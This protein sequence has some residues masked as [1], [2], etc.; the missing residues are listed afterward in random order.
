MAKLKRALKAIQEKKKQDVIRVKKIIQKNI[1]ANRG[2]NSGIVKVQNSKEVDGVGIEKKNVGVGR[3]Q[4]EFL[5]FDEGLTLLVGEGNFSFAKALAMK[6]QTGENIIATCLDNE[7]EVLLK[8]PDASE[9]IQEFQ[10]MGGTVFYSVDATKLHNNRKLKSKKFSRI[11]FNFPHVGMKDM[12]RNILLNKSLI[13]QFFQSTLH[14]PS[15]PK[16]FITLK[17]GSP[18]DQWD[19]KKIAKEYGYVCETSV[20]FDPVEMGVEGYTHRRTV[21]FEEGLSKSGNEE[22]RN[23]RMYLFRRVEVGEDE[24]VGKKRR[25]KDDESDDEK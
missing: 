5:K 11:I 13:Q 18:Y 4:S 3:I 1:Y 7:E 24:G 2:V 23:S 17:E 20:K 22:I 15:H 19:V 12:H 6:L 8:Y 10:E 9:H 21:G 16:I 14:F 25:K